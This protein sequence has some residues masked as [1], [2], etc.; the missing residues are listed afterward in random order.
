MSPAAKYSDW[1][2]P[3]NNTSLQ[4]LKEL[5]FRKYHCM[6]NSPDTIY[7]DWTLPESNTGLQSLK[8]LML[9]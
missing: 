8:L 3:E 9:R 5:M 2:L 7:S 6:N 1:T 4:R